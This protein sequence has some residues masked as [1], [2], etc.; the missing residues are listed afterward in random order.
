MPINQNLPILKLHSFIEDCTI[1]KEWSECKAPVFFDFGAEF[2]LWCLLPKTS[3]GN[4]YMLEYSKQNFIALHTDS[5]NG[6][7]FFDL[8]NFL[9]RAIF[10]Y[11]NPGVNTTTPKTAIETTHP[12]QRQ[13][14]RFPLISTNDIRW[15]Q[16]QI[17]PRQQ[18]HTYKSR[19]FK[20]W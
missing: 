5:L 11:E 4:Y 2:P 18:R 14:I 8:M 1:I 6:N 16:N 9:Y 3:N 7:S 10:A 17:T 13:T 12:I 20:R 19:R 15:L